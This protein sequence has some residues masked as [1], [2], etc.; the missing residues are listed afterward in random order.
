ME[1]LPIAVDVGEGEGKKTVKGMLRIEPFNA[2]PAGVEDIK[3]QKQFIR[4]R[5]LSKD[6]KSMMEDQHAVK[7]LQQLGSDL[8]INAFA[9]NFEVDSQVNQDIVSP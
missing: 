8:M 1:P 9:C 2:L 5:I 3:D 6:N 4:E 7:L